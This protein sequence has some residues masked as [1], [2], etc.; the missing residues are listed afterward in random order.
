MEEKADWIFE[1]LKKI[2]WELLAGQ[3]NNQR[4][5]YK[6]LK[7]S[8]RLLVADKL[9]FFNQH[10]NLTYNRI[11]IKNQRSCWGSA[12]Q[13]KNLNFN[14]KIVQ[15]PEELQNYLIV[16]ELCHLKEMNHS[17]NFWNLVAETVPNFKEIRK[18]LRNF[19]PRTN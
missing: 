15:L 2:D 16:H 9:E 10:Y 19:N 18:K 8:A 7:K 17:R 13:K 12:S 1:K 11:S 14:Y 5:D 4:N 3:K 6:K